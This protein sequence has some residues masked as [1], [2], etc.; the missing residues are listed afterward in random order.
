M[1]KLL[2]LAL[3][4]LN[5]TI[6]YSQGLGQDRIDRLRRSVVRVLINGEASGTGFFVSKDG[7]ILTNWHVI[8]PALKANELGISIEKKISIE[9]QDG[10]TINIEGFVNPIFNE[11][12]FEAIAYDY[13]L[14]KIE[15]MPKQSF[16]PLNLKSMSNVN[17]GDF[18]ITCGYPLGLKQQFISSGLL[19]T[20]FVQ[21]DTLKLPLKDT[22]IHKN[23]AW[24]D[25]TMNK[26][27][28]GGQ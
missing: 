10:E 4:I 1:R 12:L 22:V 6:A 17:E 11:G 27:N 21:S 19:S 3:I 25:I 9:F 2:S 20:K 13:C 18:V 14:M 24:L 15:K 28:S 5:T 26:G 7:A 16:I 8:A 23:A